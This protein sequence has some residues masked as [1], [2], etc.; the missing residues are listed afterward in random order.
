MI[1]EI[2]GIDTNIKIPLKGSAAMCGRRSLKLRFKLLIED[3]LKRADGNKV[4]RRVFS[5]SL[6]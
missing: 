4:E 5:T 1:D 6:T 2:G 3:P